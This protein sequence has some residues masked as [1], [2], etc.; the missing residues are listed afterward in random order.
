MKLPYD[1]YISKPAIYKN[2]PHF[3]AWFISGLSAVSSSISSSVV[4]SGSLG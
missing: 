4:S 3:I 1:R 2:L